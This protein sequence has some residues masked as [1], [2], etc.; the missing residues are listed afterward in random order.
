MVRNVA[1]QEIA[2]FLA[3]FWRGKTPLAEPL[4]ALVQELA[5]GDVTLIR[6]ACFTIREMTDRADLRALA[7]VVLPQR[8]RLSRG[9]LGGAVVPNSHWRELAFAKLELAVGDACFCNLYARSEYFDPEKEHALGKVLV[10]HTTDN[11]AR[12][13]SDYH[14]RCTSCAQEFDVQGETGWHL[15]WWK[16]TAR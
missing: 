14:C 9:D 11:A 6:Q 8:A 4:Q 15:P 13:A 16:W 7:A 1:R 2:G 3:R 12:Q 10:V 5:S